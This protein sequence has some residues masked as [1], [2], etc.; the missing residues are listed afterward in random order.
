[1]AGTPQPTLVWVKLGQMSENLLKS[2]RRLQIT[3]DKLVIRN[4]QITDAGVY[5]C[6]GSNKLGDDE[7]VVTLN[8]KE[9]FEW[10]P[11]ESWGAC[12]QTCGEGKQL[13]HRKCKRLDITAECTE[14]DS[15][16]RKCEMMRCPI[17]G[18]WSEF[19][20]WQP[21]SPTC[22]EENSS[23]IPIQIRK[24]FCNAPVPKFDGRNCQGSSLEKRTCTLRYC[25]IDGK[26]S[27]WNM[28]SPCSVTCGN[29][30]QVIEQKYIP[31]KYGGKDLNH[32]KRS[33]TRRNAACFEKL[34]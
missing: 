12:S 22:V 13:R 2:D 10:L 27:A 29:G 21:C 11:W 18:G 6:R 34:C 8:V 33:P 32:I 24:R 20:D 28:V 14:T 15:E 9:R 19:G 25:P 26:L 23:I 4:I 30:I 3:D 31:A 17:D 7:I 16:S 5:K 1:M